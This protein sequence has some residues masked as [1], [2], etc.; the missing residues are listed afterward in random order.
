MYV[1]LVVIVPPKSS[2]IEYCNHSK[3]GDYVKSPQ[4]SGRQYWVWIRP[5]RASIKINFFNTCERSV[6]RSRVEARGQYSFWGRIE[7]DLDGAT[8]W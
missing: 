7:R 6:K 4:A 5:P 2:D 1:A 8:K 3:E